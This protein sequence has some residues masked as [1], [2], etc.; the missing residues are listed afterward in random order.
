DE[1]GN[2]VELHC[3][4]DPETRSGGPQANRKVKGTLDWVSVET[5]LDVEVRLYDRLFSDPEPDGHKDKDFKAFINPD[6]LQVISTAKVEPSL[7]S[8]SSGDRFQFIR[9]GYFCVDPDSTDDKLV[10]NRT[11]TLRDNWAK[12]QKKK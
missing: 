11:V 9:K 1:A 4:F 7:G 6:S 5:A 3:T 12:K 2:I 10:F 8:A